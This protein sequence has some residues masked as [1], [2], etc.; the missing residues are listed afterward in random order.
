M[1]RRAWYRIHPSFGLRKIPATGLAPSL[2]DTE[3]GSK[4]EAL[5]DAERDRR[6]VDFYKY[7]LT[8]LAQTYQPRFEVELPYNWERDKFLQHSD[9]PQRPPGSRRE[10]FSLRGSLTLKAAECLAELNPVILTL[11]VDD[12]LLFSL[13]DAWSSASIRLGREQA[14]ELREELERL[15]LVC[16]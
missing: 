5:S 9:T 8:Y 1:T 12:E 13:G 7:I 10:D 4:W 11:S 2:T 3:L 16:Y 14:L 6:E 15:S